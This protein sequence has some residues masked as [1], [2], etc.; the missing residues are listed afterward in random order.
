MFFVF[1]QKR[2]VQ[3]LRLFVNAKGFGAKGAY[4]ADL[5]LHGGIQAVTFVF[6]VG[7]CN[8]RSDS[9]A[10]EDEFHFIAAFLEFFGDFQRVDDPRQIGMRFTFRENYQTDFVCHWDS[11][12]LFCT[13]TH[14]PRIG[15]MCR[16]WG[17]DLKAALR[18]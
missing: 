6:G 18:L 3:C 2:D 14:R 11:F 10:I 4:A 12:V 13:A 9:A 16:P 5:V 17:C 15:T 1:I 8:R 7:K